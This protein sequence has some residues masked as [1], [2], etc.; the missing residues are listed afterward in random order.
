MPGKEEEECKSSHGGRKERDNSL[1][2]R[3]F[4]HRHRGLTR[5][6]VVSHPVFLVPLPP[7]G[8][9]ERVAKGGRTAS[10]RERATPRMTQVPQSLTR[11]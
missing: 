2:R 3:P 4:V 5:V 6:S 8:D 1:S 11:L 10:V 7:S 9:G